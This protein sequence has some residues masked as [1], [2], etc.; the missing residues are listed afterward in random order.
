MTSE[1]LAMRLIALE[2]LTRS[3]IKPLWDSI[4]SVIRGKT[5]APNLTVLL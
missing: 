4:N 5:F 3:L 1:H 2:A